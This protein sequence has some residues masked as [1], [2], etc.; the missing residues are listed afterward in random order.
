MRFMHTPHIIKQVI[1]DETW[2]L[3]L[4]YAQHPD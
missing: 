4:G 2:L 3:N 1:Y